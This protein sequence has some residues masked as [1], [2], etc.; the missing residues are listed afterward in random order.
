MDACLVTAVSGHTDSSSRSA[1][2]L[3]CLSLQDGLSF[4]HIGSWIG[5]ATAVHS[6]TLVSGPCGP[7]DLTAA[8]APAVAAATASNCAVRAVN[9]STLIPVLLQEASKTSQQHLLVII[10]AN[11]SLGVG[12]SAGDIPIRRHVIMAGLY[13]RPTSVDFGMVVNQLVGTPTAVVHISTSL[14]TALFHKLAD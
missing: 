8:A 1:A 14:G 7:R 3:W 13:T 6:V 11:V 5:E 2:L 4:L 10:T 12:L 9:N